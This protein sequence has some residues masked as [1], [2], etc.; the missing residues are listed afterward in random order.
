MKT[1]KIS[2]LLITTLF[3]SCEAEIPI[4]DTTAPVFT[5][6]IT[7]DG[8]NRTFDQDTDFN[9]LQLNLRDDTPYDFTYTGADDGGVELIQLQMDTPE[10]IVLE[11]AIPSPW[12]RTNLGLSQM[13]EWRGDRNNPLTGNLINGRFRTNAQ[14]VSIAVRF[15]VRDF[16]GERRI[17]NS[18]YGTLNLF[19]GNHPTEIIH[20]N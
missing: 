5:F 14:L 2:I 7:G 3:F 9:S 12:T 10:Y 11:T 20:I 16:G 13:I 4:T 17:S 1:L 6:Q 8:F 18:S 19:P 15:Y